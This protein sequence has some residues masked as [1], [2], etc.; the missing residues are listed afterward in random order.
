MTASPDPWFFFDKIYCIS[1]DTRIDRK[2]EAQKQF[3]TVGLLDKVEFVLVKKHPDNPEQGIFE[4][5]MR[6]LKKGLQAGGKHI[7]IFED[8]IF[9]KTFQPEKIISATQ[10]LE[11]RK[12]WKAFFLGA[13]SSKITATEVSSVVKLQYRCLAHA[14]A[15]NRPFAEKFVQE[16]WNNIA[17]DE[18]LKQK[19]KEFYALSPMLAFQG[20]ASSDNRTIF[21]DK[22][23]RLFGGLAFIQH[24]NEFYQKHKLAVI[25]SHG[26]LTLGAL[27]LIAKLWK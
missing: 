20:E 25:M 11:N 1:I 19:C 16:P 5:H 12:N 9:F 13:I 14:Y 7:L 26:L 24:M 4:A 3:S 10:F 17:F 27:L 22:M 8:D 6:C 23:R 21:L 15:L 2:T 18:L